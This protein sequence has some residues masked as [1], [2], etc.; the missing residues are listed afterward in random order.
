M[1][2]QDMKNYKSAEGKKD[3]KSI[4]LLTAITGVLAA[5]GINSL[6]KEAKEGPA[7]SFTG[8]T[9]TASAR[10]QALDGTQFRGVV[11]ARYNMPSTYEMEDYNRHNHFFSTGIG[12]AF[13]EV[14]GSKSSKDIN[15]NF[16]SVARQ[17]CNAAANGLP[18]INM[19]GLPAQPGVSLKPQ[20]VAC[21]LW[22]DKSGQSITVYAR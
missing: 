12:A 17:F 3:Y 4:L 7:V 2:M 5:A 8:K 18:D 10:E 15:A 14:V 21:T 6:V 20:N 22:N 9:Q 13:Y 11:S 19:D 16:A 1:Q